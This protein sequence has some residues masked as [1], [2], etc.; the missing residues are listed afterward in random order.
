MRN[1]KIREKQRHEKELV[2]RTRSFTDRAYQL[3]FYG[4]VLADGFGLINE[5][6][7]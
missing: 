1:K 2:V 5:A 3:K 4:D 6:R 7:D